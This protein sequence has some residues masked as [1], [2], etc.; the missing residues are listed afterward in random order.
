MLPE[1][2][3][4]PFDVEFSLELR[5]RQHRMR[6]GGIAV[7]TIAELREAAD[8]DSNYFFHGVPT[9]LRPFRQI[10]VGQVSA[11][12]LGSHVL[13][14]SEQGLLF[15][16]GLN[17]YGQLGIGVKTP[18]GGHHRGYVMTPTIVTPLVENGGKAIACAAGVDHSLVVV[19]TEERRLVKSRSF[20][21]PHSP[22]RTKSSGRPGT[23]NG[24]AAD[25]TEYIVYHQVYGFGR[26]DSMKIGLVSPTLSPQTGPEDETD[27]V[28]LPRRVALRCKVRPSDDDEGES[29]AALPPQGIF[30]IQASEQHSAALVRRASGDIELYTWGNAADGALG[31]SPRCSQTSSPTNSAG[32]Q[33][34]SLN[35]EQ[36]QNGSGNSIDRN[37]GIG[38]S[39]SSI[40]VESVPSCVSMLSRTSNTDTLAS[41]L[42]RKDENEYP[43]R[44]ALGRRCSFVLTSLGRC[45][46]FGTS[47]DG[48]LGLGP[49]IT[50]AHQPSEI[51]FPTELRHGTAPGDDR[52]V[53]V[54]AGASHVL[55]NTE[56]G[57]VVAWGYHDTFAPSE[58]DEHQPIHSKRSNDSSDGRIIDWS[59]RLVEIE[60]TCAS[61]NL[62]RP[63]RP[64]SP[65]RRKGH[66]QNDDSDRDPEGKS[67]QIVVSAACAGYECSV[68]VT[69]SGRVLS[70]GSNSGRLGLGECRQKTVHKPRP[71]FGGLRLWQEHDSYQ[72]RSLA[73]AKERKIPPRR[74]M[75]RGATVS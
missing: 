12:P 26:N 51:I 48:M 72:R 4:P 65:R 10:K 42:L 15:S 74:M 13:L 57:R 44:I 35:D 19:M 63:P 36:H 59:P 56:H 23:T 61:K 49:K 5:Q 73:V 17:E 69:Q 2:Y 45:F 33:K 34:I 28:V 29:D 6:N 16:Y 20:E 52:V 24:A 21:P 54:S 27:A 53:C 62:N 50:E 39:R 64:L 18:V 41:S 66:Y 9:F 68:F 38:S 31:Y 70:C 47:S 40:Y 1:S 60:E 55:A 22:S 25:D 32:F 67:E 14:I 43:S 71:L 58:V 7:A 30:S 11:H 46:S 8:D 3:Y 37:P 75:A